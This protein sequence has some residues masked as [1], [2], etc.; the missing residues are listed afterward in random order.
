MTW[1][2]RTANGCVENLLGIVCAMIRVGLC[3]HPPVR[4]LQRVWKGSVC[5]R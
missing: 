1:E 5:D 3:P 2:S 4:L